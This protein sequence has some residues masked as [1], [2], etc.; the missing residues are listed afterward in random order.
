MCIYFYHRFYKVCLS[1]TS[2]VGS[3]YSGLAKITIYY[4]PD[5]ATVFKGKL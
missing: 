5:I 1:P 2:R 4:V 3:H